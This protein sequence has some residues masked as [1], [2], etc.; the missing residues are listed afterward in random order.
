[1][2][3]QA[4]VDRE[5]LAKLLNISSKQLSYITNSDAGSGLLRYGPA[6]IASL[7]GDLGAE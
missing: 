5:R 2:L 7:I 1:M 3:N 4:A 6:L